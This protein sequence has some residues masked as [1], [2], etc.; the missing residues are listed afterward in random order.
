MADRWNYED[1]SFRSAIS[2]NNTGCHL[3]EKGAYE[4][5]RET[6]TDCL[7][8]L[9]RL[10]TLDSIMLTEEYS[11]QLQET[12]LQNASRRMAFPQS[13]S[14]SGSRRSFEQHSEHHGGEASVGVGDTNHTLN[15]SVRV[16]SIWECMESGYLDGILSSDDEKGATGNELFIS[17]FRIEDVTL[18][19]LGYNLGTVLFNLGTSYSALA[20]CCTNNIELRDFAI[21]IF[22]LADRSLH[23]SMQR[24]D[25][26]KQERNNHVVRLFAC[27]RLATLF[28]LLQCCNATAQVRVDEIS[29]RMQ[30]LQ[31][32]IDLSEQLTCGCDAVTW[33]RA[34][35]AA[36]A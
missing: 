14:P 30:Q 28:G 10:A 19:R 9:Q 27:A 12:L 35:P 6:F 29:R 17:P 5:A 31:R 23:V 7:F 2:L 18:T 1:S 16:V 33:E 13:M 26:Q 11:L 21:K 20:R 3:L 32:A 22:L 36:S 34:L 4:Q 24:C 8:L 15:Q 25:S